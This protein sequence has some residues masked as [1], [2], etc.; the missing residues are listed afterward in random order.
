MLR[1]DC[2]YALKSNGTSRKIPLALY[3]KHNWLIFGKKKCPNFFT[4]SLICVTIVHTQII[5]F[6]Q[7]LSSAFNIE[8]WRKLHE[9]CVSRI[10]YFE[11]SS[12][13][14]AFIWLKYHK[15]KT[16][17]PNCTACGV[18]MIPSKACKYFMVELLVCPLVIAML[19]DNKT[20]DK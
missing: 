4:L 9:E 1:N 5:D 2:S 3:L 11:R 18:V 7:Y 6:L 13:V 20:I 14:S 12:L 16:H 8:S 10:G 19:L 17:L 15:K